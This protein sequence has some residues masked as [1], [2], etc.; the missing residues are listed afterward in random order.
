MS[1]PQAYYS[2]VRQ[3]NVG[4]D[5]QRPRSAA[6][7]GA[8]GP[9][10]LNATWRAPTYAFGPPPLSCSCRQSVPTQHGHQFFFPADPIPP[11][12]PRFVGWICSLE[13]N[14]RA[15]LAQSL[16]RR[17][18]LVDQRDDNLARLRCVLLANDDGVVLEDAGLD[19]RIAAHLKGEVFAAAQEFRRHGQGLKPRLDGRD[20]GAGGDPAHHWHHDRRVVVDI[21][22]RPKRPHATEIARDDA[23]RELLQPWS[24]DG[25][26]F[27]QPQNFDRSGAIGQPTNEAA[28]L[29]RHDE[30]MN[31]GFRA[32]IQRLFH[33]VERRRHTLILQA[34]MDKT[35]QLALL[36]CQHL[37]LQ[38]T[39]P[40][41]VG[42]RSG[43]S[44]FWL[45]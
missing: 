16:E 5:A 33:F 17:F 10:G 30:P 3:H 27:W 2:I 21:T 4:G 35:Q 36:F 28:L 14:R 18:L 20:R 43:E 44:R 32:Q 31:S 22:R 45:K 15:P 13:R 39:R 34:L 25:R 23:W 19:H 24:C 9:A 37:S 26:R 12:D 41:T 11:E 8:A 6:T 38:I 42:V 7:P 1:V 29:E 40:F